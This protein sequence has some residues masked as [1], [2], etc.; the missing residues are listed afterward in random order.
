ME[1]EI[2]LAKESGMGIIAKKAAMAVANRHKELQ[3]IPGWRI[4]KV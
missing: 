3:F 4:Q 1:R 2:E